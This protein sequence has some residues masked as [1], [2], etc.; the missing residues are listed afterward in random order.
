MNDSK[1][2]E[3]R[4]TST[5]ETVIRIWTSALNCKDSHIKQRSGCVMTGFYCV[6]CSLMSQGLP[7][8]I[9]KL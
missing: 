3:T 7:V 5:R 4:G 9:L 6:C 1:V 8:I 2:A